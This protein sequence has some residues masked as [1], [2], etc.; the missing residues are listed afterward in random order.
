MAQSLNMAFQI[1]VL[2]PV[3]PESVL[4]LYSWIDAASGYFREMMMTAKR[5]SSA[6]PDIRRAI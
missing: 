5:N 4:N 1:E 3:P 2:P 6:V